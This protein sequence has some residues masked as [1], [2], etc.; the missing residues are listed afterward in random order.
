MLAALGFAVPERTL[1][2]RPGAC[3]VLAKSAP[4]EIAN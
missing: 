1:I 3:K 4:A 2:G